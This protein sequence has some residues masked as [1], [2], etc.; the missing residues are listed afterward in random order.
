MLVLKT[1]SEVRQAVAQYRKHGKTIGFV[2]TMGAL[3]DGHISLVKRSFEENFATIVSVFVNP[4]QFNNKEDLEKYPRTLQD[5]VNLL[6]QSGCDIVFAPEVEE[7][8]PQPDTRQFELG[9]V[10]EVMEGKFRPGHFNGVC[11]VVSKLLT[12][13][14]PDKA[15]FGQKDYQQIAVIRT[16]LSK[17]YVPEFKGELVPCPIKRADDGL[18]LSS[19]NQRL[20]PQQ[21]ISALTISKAL[22]SAKDKVKDGATANDLRKYIEDTIS[23]DSNLKIEY[24]EIADK[25]TL[26]STN[27]LHNAIIC[28]AVYDGDV[29][30]ID[31]ILL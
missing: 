29:R 2:P 23:F 18:A 16:M 3:H 27:D 8:Y 30:L 6:Q 4:T 21:R 5:D 13:T 9:M 22:F 25:D 31:N 11:Q 26:C 28:V 24:V 14:T 17:G 10:A 7:M 1:I 15:Y 19:R 12:I 20:S